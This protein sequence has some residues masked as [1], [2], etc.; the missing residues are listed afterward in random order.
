MTGGDTWGA[1][2]TYEQAAKKANSQVF[3]S[4]SASMTLA[5]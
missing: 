5:E 1:Q 3:G 2:K 4:V